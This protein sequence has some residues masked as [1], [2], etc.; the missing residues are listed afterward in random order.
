MGLSPESRRSCALEWPLI[1]L[2]SVA[3]R[4]SG[5][6]PNKA[7]ADFWNG[8]IPWISLKDSDGLDKRYIEETAETITPAGIANSSAVVHPPGTVVLSRDAGVGKS[9]IMSR[10]M[11]VSQHFIAWRCGPSLDNEFLYYW[12]QREKPEF[13]R[14]AIGNTIKTI[15]LAYFKALRIPLPP[16]EEQLVIAGALRDVDLALYALGEFIA[17]KRDLKQ[18]A[19]QQLLTGKRRLPGFDDD[20][21]WT[22]LDQVAERATG[23][24][25][26]E[27]RD[28]QHVN[29][30]EIIRAGDI[31][32]GGRLTGTAHRFLSMAELA[33]ARCLLDDVVITTSGNGLGKVW[34][35]DGR[36]EV[37]ASNFVRVLRPIRGEAIGRFLAH[38]IGGDESAR[39]LRGHTA[40]S[41]YPNLRPTYFTTQWLKLPSPEEQTAIAAV[42]SD[43]EAELIALE[44]R[45]AKTRDLKQGMMQE[46][47]TGRTRLI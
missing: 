13:E 36:P 23:A 43:M 1:P 35:C 17:K 39:Q 45:L 32:S 8:E 28:G 14:V 26:T 47:L 12:L 33:K 4:G 5:H 11:A 24:W 2:E 19:M 22:C 9:G 21:R 10:P 44:A 16:I 30:A 41:A 34:W 31:S 38:L 29:A 20:W 15:G 46:L 25:G 37:A 27:D 7:R 40:T 18:A 3:I 42:L 6:T